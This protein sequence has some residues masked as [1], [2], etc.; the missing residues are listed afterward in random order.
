MQTCEVV[1]TEPSTQHTTH[2][3]DRCMDIYTHHVTWILCPMFGAFALAGNKYRPRGLMHIFMA[4]HAWVLVFICET[5]ANICYLTTTRKNICQY[6]T[7]WQYVIIASPQYLMICI[8]MCI[9]SLNKEK[10][11]SKMLLHYFFGLQ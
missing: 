8:I 7:I 9:I 2:F 6:V 3:R 10:K 11:N 5:C 1:W 4:F